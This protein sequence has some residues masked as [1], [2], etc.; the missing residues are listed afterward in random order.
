MNIF[1]NHVNESR[2]KIYDDSVKLLKSEVTDFIN[3]VNKR[4]PVQVKYVI[5]LTQKYNLMDA[6][7]I[8]EIRKANKQKLKDLSEKYNISLDEMEELWKLLKDLKH[9]VKLLP[10]YLTPNEI[11][12]LKAGELSMNDLTIDLSTPAGRNATAKYFMPMVYKIVDGFVGMTKLNRSDLISAGNLA[13]VNAMNSWDRSTGVSFKTYLG[14]RI[15]QQIMGDM[16]RYG[17]DLSTGS[18]HNN[19]AAVKYGDKL[20]A[21]SL[22]HKLDSGDTL[23][24]LIPD[25]SRKYVEP[26]WTEFYEIIDKEFSTRKAD[27]FYRVMGLNGRKKE[28]A[29]DVAKSYGMSQ[30]NINNSVIN[31]I[32]K[33]ISNNRKMMSMLKA[34]NESYNISLMISMFGMS[35]E[36][37]LETMVNDDIY[38]LLEEVNRWSNE[39]LFKDTLETSLERLDE[40]DANYIRDVLKDDFEFL[41]GSFKKHRKII[42]LFLSEMYPTESM[43]KKTDV[44]LLDY[45]SEIQNIYKKYYL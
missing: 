15:R 43:G 23:G 27:I 42:I 11:E 36:E 31:P 33:F 30:S 32:K 3:K 45:M 44:A 10:Q 38:I 40:L 14:R 16:S 5:S 7:S 8:D 20:K 4:I 24:E 9:N 39:A 41:D 25:R 1:T 2:R 22:D 34:L 26:D 13:L 17:Y 12:E 19:Y 35:K 29:V 6:K 28:K 21:A 37:M 18:S